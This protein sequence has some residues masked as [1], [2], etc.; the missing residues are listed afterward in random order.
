[1]A[2]KTSSSKKPKGRVKSPGARSATP[3]KE[4]VLAGVP[5]EYEAH[6]NSV[7]S[8]AEPLP[9]Q[10][11]KFVKGF[12]VFLLMAVIISGAGVAGWLW[13]Q[14]HQVKS[15][16]DITGVFDTAL[17]NSLDTPT[18][19]ESLSLSGG[20]P[21]PTR[22]RTYDFSNGQNSKASVSNLAYDSSGDTLDLVIIGGDYYVKTHYS[23]AT[24]NSVSGNQQV[25]YIQA[26][27]QW[28]KRVSNNQEVEDSITSQLGPMTP[29]AT[30]QYLI[31]DA[32]IIGEFDGH[33]RQTLYSYAV[34]N[35]VYRI[36]SF[37]P[38]AANVDGQSTWHYVIALSKSRLAHLNQIAGSLLGI[39]DN[40]QLAQQYVAQAPG[41]I[42]VW[43]GQHSD[44]VVRYSYEL[45]GVSYTYDYSNVGKSVA[46]KAPPS[47]INA[48]A[49]PLGT[50][51]A[52]LNPN[53]LSD[54]QMTSAVSQ[55]DTALIGT[56]QPGS[57][58]S[59]PTDQTSLDSY[60]HVFLPVFSTEGV[61][62]TYGN[63]YPG[64]NQIVYQTHAV[65]NPMTAGTYVSNEP[66][67]FALVTNTSTGLYCIDS[68]S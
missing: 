15:Q 12:A 36:P 6:P 7:F 27:N 51:P 66:N 5:E 25:A 10:T 16:F 48:S 29:F 63:G 20:V 54:S 34:D 40:V 49:T 14:D 33:D 67:S 18:F 3:K 23:Q 28:V 68:A 43:I 57:G 4:E 44:R 13:W 46:I 50:Q 24:L 22:V 30:A 65:C 32:M 47:T 17:K 55:L 53:T 38:A 37:A 56:L 42:N 45:G 58:S 62:V 39:T 2:K 59:L 52:P 35:G 11:S 61:S 60:M 41:T 8:Q 19:T 31:P 64:Q 21:I 1:M 26:N 9:R